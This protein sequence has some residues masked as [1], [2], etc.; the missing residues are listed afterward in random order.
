MSKP[1]SLREFAEFSRSEAKN[2]PFQADNYFEYCRN[3][4]YSTYAA[5]V[6]TNKIDG[7]SLLSL[8]AGSAYVEHALVKWHGTTV[9]IVDFPE[10]LAAMGPLYA[11]C[12]FKAVA[13]DITTG[14]QGMDGYFDAALSSEV[15]EHLPRPPAEHIR[16][17]GKALKP[18]GELERFQLDC[19]YPQL[20]R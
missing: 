7:G 19:P 16:I 13:G 18:D 3:R 6:E 8:G 15:V 11:K 10:T 17:L 12:G 1:R 20:A 5:C 9:T 2:R 14:L 4:L